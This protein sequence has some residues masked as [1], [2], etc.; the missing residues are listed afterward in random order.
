MPDAVKPSLSSYLSRRWI[1]QTHVSR[2]CRKPA[3]QFTRFLKQSEDA[4][5][6]RASETTVK[7]TPDHSCWHRKK[8]SP[9]I[10]TSQTS[11]TTP[12]QASASQC[13]SLHL[14][15]F[16]QIRLDTRS[17]ANASKKI[18]SRRLR[19]VMC[20]L[21]FQKYPQPRLHKLSWKHSP[22]KKASRSLRL[23]M[24]ALRFQKFP[25]TRLHKLFLYIRSV[26]ER[27]ENDRNKFNNSTSS[28]ASAASTDSSRHNNTSPPSNHF[29]TARRRENSLLQPNRAVERAVH[30][31]EI[32]PA[33]ISRSRRLG[34]L[35]RHTAFGVDTNQIARKARACR[36][37]EIGVA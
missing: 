29:L 33:M 15:G 4:S 35:S 9:Q 21:R 12:L 22:K 7:M 20:I 16:P 6:D 3:P 23:P 13:A 18:A 32:W 31:C 37:R 5:E 30:H 8:A 24:C 36:Q 25:Q 26:L 1:S 28:Q 27:K 17:P 2:F 10:I 34:P 11:H 14:Q 19:L